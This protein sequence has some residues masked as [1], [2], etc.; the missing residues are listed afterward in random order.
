MIILVIKHP[1]GDNDRARN[2]NINK[3]AGLRFPSIS[4]GTTRTTWPR[5]KP[6]PA[7][8]TAD[9]TFEQIHLLNYNDNKNAYFL[10][11][12]I[13][14]TVKKK[15]L[16]QLAPPILYRNNNPSSGLCITCRQ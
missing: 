3:P 12:E 2:D 7:T 16:K 10:I 13:L 11:C 1:Y 5:T 4:R 8:N 15:R 9:V 14:N 6:V